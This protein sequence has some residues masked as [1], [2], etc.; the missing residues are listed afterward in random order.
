MNDS[1][2]SRARVTWS[3]VTQKSTRGHRISSFQN[4]F[5]VS[6]I[7]LFVFGIECG[8]AY[9]FNISNTKNGKIPNK[10]S[11]RF[12]RV[13]MVVKIIISLF[14]SCVYNY[15]WR[16]YHCFLVLFSFSFFF[17]LFLFFRFNCLVYSI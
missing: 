9:L 2:L 4:N 17:F 1:N 13:K 11:R 5:N 14:K 7:I 15:V 3:H 6:Q 16:S 12:L 10:S 8:I